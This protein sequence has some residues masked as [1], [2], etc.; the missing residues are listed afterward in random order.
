MNADLRLIRINEPSRH[1]VSRPAGPRVPH[2]TLRHEHYTVTHMYFHTQS[3]D[4]RP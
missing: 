2:I 3:F 1:R 4:F